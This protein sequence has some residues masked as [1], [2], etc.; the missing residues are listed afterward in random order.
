[1]FEAGVSDNIC[2][3]PALF[4]DK[5]I[6]RASIENLR[7]KQF[8]EGILE[9]DYILITT[10]LLNHYFPYSENWCVAPEQVIDDN[11]KP[12]FIVSEIDTTEPNYGVSYPYLN[13]EVKRP[14]VMSWK[15]LLDD[16]LHKQCDINCGNNPRQTNGKL[17]AM[18]QKGFEICLFLFD[19]HINLNLDNYT[20]FKAI[21]PSNLTVA[22][23]KSLGARPFV[24]EINGVDV[25]IAITWKIDNPKH[26]K[27]IHEMF[28]YVL[29]HR[30]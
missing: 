15:K 1:M 21:N 28:L 9:S 8:D 19:I 26:T 6:T 29:E 17:W 4:I 3:S 10:L 14:R 22:T 13:V 23:L 20:Q 11:Y 30:A 7:R 27:H 12:D 18:G 5:E 16:Q 2:F 24:K 25:I